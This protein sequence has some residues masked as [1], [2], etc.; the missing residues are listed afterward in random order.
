MN[1]VRLSPWRKMW[2]FSTVFLAHHFPEAR[3]SLSP[4]DF[5]SIKQA[6]KVPG[7]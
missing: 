6:L 7:G 4:L 1:L 2:G 3:K 5:E